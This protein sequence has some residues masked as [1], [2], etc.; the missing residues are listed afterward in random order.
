[1]KPTLAD[2]GRHATLRRLPKPQSAVEQATAELRHAILTGRLE[3]GERL[4]INL[5]AEELGI[6]HIPLREALRRLESNGL[7]VLSKARN[8]SVAQLSRGELDAIYRM[9]LR[10]EPELA[11]EAA[12]GFDVTQIDGLF[13]ILDE[14]WKSQGP[15]DELWMQHCQFHAALLRPAMTPWDQRMLDQMWHASERYTRIAFETHDI[16]PGAWRE[17]VARHRALVDAI[18]SRS[19]DKVRASV[20]EHLT[21]S[22]ER[23]QTVFRD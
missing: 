14:D 9:R 8:P 21:G 4:Q 13:A 23:C 19:A 18:A 3:P 2:P 1:M 10:V 22:W 7:V 16:A 12:A 11:V 17:R 15:S 5:L 20:I 6:S